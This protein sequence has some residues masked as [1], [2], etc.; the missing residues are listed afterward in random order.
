MFILSYKHEYAS[1]VWSPIRQQML[2]NIKLCSAGLPAGLPVASVI[3]KLSLSP[4]YSGP[5]VG[6][7]CIDS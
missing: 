6:L 7:D 5:V 3:V 2:L 1:T 4:W